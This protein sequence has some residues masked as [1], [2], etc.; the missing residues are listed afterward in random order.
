MGQGVVAMK[1][2]Q[3]IGIAVAATAGVMA[4]VMVRGMVN[5]VS[6][7]FKCEG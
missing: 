7:L 3:L 4:F 5:K 1:R 6:Y 2:P